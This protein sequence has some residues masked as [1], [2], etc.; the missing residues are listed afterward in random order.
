MEAGM[1]SLQNKIA[2][3]TG[4]GGGIGSATALVLA[5]RGAKV[6]AAEL[7][8]ESALATVKQ[9]RNLGGWAEA[10]EFNLTEAD[11]IKSAMN[12]V[13]GEQGR[14]D[15]LFN[16]AADC[17]PEAFSRDRDVEAL[18]VATWDRAFSIN[19]RGTM[20]SCKFALPHMPH[21]AGAS[22]INT[23]SNTG[24]QGSLMLNSYSCSKAAILQLT[25]NIATSHGKFGIRC[26]TVTPGLILTSKIEQDLP[27]PFRDIVESE[28]LLPSL[29]EPNDIAYTV[30]FLASDEAKYITGQNIVVDGGTWV[31]TPGFA[32]MRNLFAQAQ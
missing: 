22:I 13:A 11:Q 19:L 32:Q 15:V 16:C 2:V 6:Y 27:K 18:D 9:I 8:L 4:A 3:I 23:A 7:R 1:I 5:G 28:T 12:K 25:R 29:G 21:H 30:A 14:I 26:N 17:S 20:L 10:L 24:L 31:H